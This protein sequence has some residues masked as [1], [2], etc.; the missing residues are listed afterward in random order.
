MTE[1]PPP[2]SGPPP[3]GGYGPPPPGYGPPPPGYGPPPP[4][5]GPPPPG[6]GPPPP[7]YLPPP[8]YGPAPSSNTPTVLGVLGIVFAF[9]CWPVGLGL[10]IASW[11]QSTKEPDGNTALGI[12][13]TVVSGILAL[14]QVLSLARGGSAFFFRAG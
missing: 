13:A 10:G 1:P 3:E 2:P 5:Y 14:I 4:G 9:C 12:I 6:Y 11:V 7:G 8:G